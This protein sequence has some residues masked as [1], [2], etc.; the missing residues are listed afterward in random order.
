MKRFYQEVTVVEQGDQFAVAL[1]GKLVKTPGRTDL[2]VVQK[3]LA[4]AVANEW[5][6]QQEKI[7]PV[8]MPVTQ[9]VNTVLDRIPTQRDKIVEEISAYAHTDLL[10]Y[11]ADYPQELCLEQEKKWKP[12]LSWAQLRLGV[13][14]ACA[15]GIM[16]ITQTEETFFAIYN[17]I[18]DCDDWQLAALQTATLASGSVLLGLAMLDNHLSAE[19]VFDLCQLDE[20]FQMVQW[21]EDPETLARQLVIRRDLNSAGDLF[22]FLRG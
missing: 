17:K 10:C 4:L 16:P 12:V 5:A 18:S 15:A 14:I 11:W 7:D 19:Q 21:G 6:A 1:D 22:R 2:C 20:N 9:L 3:D 8:T 13:S